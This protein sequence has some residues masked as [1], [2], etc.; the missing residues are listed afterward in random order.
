MFVRRCLQSES[1]LVKAIANHGV[2]HGRMTST[3]GRNV[4]KCSE[5]LSTSVSVL[6]SNLP[7][8]I[9]NV[10][11]Q[12]FDYEMYCRALATYEFL[13]LRRF[14]LTVPKFEQLSAADIRECLASVCTV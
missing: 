14:I 1:V 3:L 10:S 13:M 9:D 4:Q 12:R 7:V 5:H 6:L 11:R 2:H 8:A